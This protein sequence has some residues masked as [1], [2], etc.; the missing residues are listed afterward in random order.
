MYFYN[1]NIHVGFCLCVVI[2]VAM[3]FDGK[4]FKIIYGLYIHPLTVNLNMRLVWIQIFK[5]A[6]MILTYITMED[7]DI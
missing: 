3:H 1:A 6:I 4:V 5:K 2:V 7:E